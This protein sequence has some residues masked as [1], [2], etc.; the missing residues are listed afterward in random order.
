MVLRVPDTYCSNAI[1][2]CHVEASA[3]VVETK[4]EKPSYA[5]KQGEEIPTKLLILELMFELALRVE[6]QFTRSGGK[7]FWAE[8]SAK[9]SLREGSVGNGEWLVGIEWYG[10]GWNGME[11]SE[12]EEHW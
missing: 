7:I 11:W 4:R 8:E 10:M 1:C 5:C 9:Q 2:Q 3:R 6:L 12:R